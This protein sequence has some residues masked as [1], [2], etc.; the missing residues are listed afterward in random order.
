ME[1]EKQHE[2]CFMPVLR[3]KVGRYAQMLD[4]RDAAVVECRFL[5][6]RLNAWQVSMVFCGVATALGSL[7]WLISAR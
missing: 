7:V 1:S 6:W 2:P 4:P 3:H 5:V